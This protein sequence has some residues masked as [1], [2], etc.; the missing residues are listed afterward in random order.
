MSVDKAQVRAFY[1]ESREGSRGRH[2]DTFEQ[3]GRRSV[4]VALLKRIKLS[5]PKA[6]DI[7]CGAGWLMKEVAAAIGGD[8]IGTDISPR[9]LQEANEG[10]FQTPFVAMDA[11]ALS[12]KSESL[13]LVVC[14]EVIEHL[15]SPQSA[16]TE[17]HR[18]VRADGWVLIT[19]PNPWAMQYQYGRFQ[20]WLYRVLYKREI[21][22]TRRQIIDDPLPPNQLNDLV[23]RVGFRLVH[24]AGSHY[25]PPVIRGKLMGRAIAEPI[26]RFIERF[27]LLPYFG[28][29]Q[30]L[31]LRKSK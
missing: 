16:L 13:D 8:F 26:S 20:R 24:R 18:V 21:A 29:Y 12:L 11:E 23:R 17:M 25:F 3:E 15:L 2:T 30:I 6:L 27:N 14:S 4:I 28:L 10:S 1:D 22:M 19:T 9:S 31:L 5:N 7:G